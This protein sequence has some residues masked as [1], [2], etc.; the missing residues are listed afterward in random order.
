MALVRRRPIPRPTRRSFSALCYLLFCCGAAMPL[1]H[2]GLQLV[3]V[4]LQLDAPPCRAL[5]SQGRVG[6][7]SCGQKGEG[8]CVHV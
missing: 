5:M 4:L 6:G 1:L 8:T 2:Q 7:V 3:V